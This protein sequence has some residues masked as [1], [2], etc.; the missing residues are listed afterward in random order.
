MPDWVKNSFKLGIII[1]V[2][3]IL[4]FFGALWCS[5]E[6]QNDIT[7]P[8]Y[9]KNTGIPF[10]FITGFLIY[11]ASKR[12]SSLILLWI[13]IA[14]IKSVADI[15]QGVP[16]IGTHFRFQFLTFLIVLPKKF[17]YTILTQMV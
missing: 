17:N 4:G 11:G 1:A 13:I 16:S 12:K 5:H 2:L 15:I 7:L 9:I 3:N 14:I 8:P 6:L 10:A